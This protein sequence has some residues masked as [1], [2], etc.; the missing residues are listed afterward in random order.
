MTEEREP[1]TRALS[2]YQYAGDDYTCYIFKEVTR[3]WYWMVLIGLVLGVFLTVLVT[4]WC[5]FGGLLRV[6]YDDDEARPYLFLE[7]NEEP[8]KITHKK[9]VVFR[10][11]IDSRQ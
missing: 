3:M 4:M 5:R 9:Y 6:H 8:E 1:L 10:V 2:L 7:L 11:K